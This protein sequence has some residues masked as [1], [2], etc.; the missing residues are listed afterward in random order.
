MI[1]MFNYKYH[2]S[3][4]FPVESCFHDEMN[5]KKTFS[6]YFYQQEVALSVN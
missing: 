2:K 5:L 3:L 6:I 4:D 1:I